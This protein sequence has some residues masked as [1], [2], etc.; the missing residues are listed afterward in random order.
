MS[1]SP[2]ATTA[3]LAWLSILSGAAVIPNRAAT[4]AESPWALCPDS[5]D[6]QN[7]ASAGRLWRL[8]TSFGVEGSSFSSS[9]AGTT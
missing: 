6:S 8:T 9:S 1:A 4:A 7:R 3:Y 5:T 2:R